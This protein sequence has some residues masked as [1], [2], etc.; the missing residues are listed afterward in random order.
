MKKGIGQLFRWHLIFCVFYYQVQ[1]LLTDRSLE[2]LERMMDPEGLVLT[3]LG[4]LIF[5]AYAL[6][7]YLVLRKYY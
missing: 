5:F 4:F 6:F 7:P 3:L 1:E 2:S